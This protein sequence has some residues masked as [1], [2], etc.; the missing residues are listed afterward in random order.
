MR[1]DMRKLRAL[2]TALLLWA[3][4]VALAA[5]E[6]VVHRDPGCGC[7]SKWAAQLRQY[8]GRPVTMLDDRNRRALQKSAGI[9]GS[10]SSCHTAVIDGL[11][12][13]GHVPF[14]DIERLLKERPK[15]VMGLAVAGMPLGS[16]GMEVTGM[17][18]QP[19]QVIAFGPG[20]QKIYARH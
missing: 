19:Y 16:P 11:L 8:T 17:K 20:G 10:L 4:A 5:G 2:V 12:F 14:K 7:C 3:P 9:P 15:G 13:E 1:H 6:I 18:P